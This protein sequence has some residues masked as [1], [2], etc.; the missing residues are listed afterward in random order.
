MVFACF[1]GVQSQQ[2]SGMFFR[3]PSAPCACTSLGKLQNLF[4]MTQ[5]WSQ[6]A[7]QTCLTR[8]VKVSEPFLPAEECLVNGQGRGHVQ[9]EQ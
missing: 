8:L 3:T 5:T 4:V 6:L 9:P 2:V 7:A 1:N